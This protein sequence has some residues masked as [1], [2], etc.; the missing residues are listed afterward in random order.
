MCYIVT[1]EGGLNRKQMWVGMARWSVSLA[2]D[3]SGVSSNH[4][5]GSR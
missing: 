1:I 4:A 2:P 3:R 5:Y